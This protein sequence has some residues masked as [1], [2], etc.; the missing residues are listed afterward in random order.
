MVNEW[1]NKALFSCIKE[2]V[3]F[4]A[5][6]HSCENGGVSLTYN[7]VVYEVMGQF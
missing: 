1:L 3:S 5:F 4:C 2:T 7:L 6:L